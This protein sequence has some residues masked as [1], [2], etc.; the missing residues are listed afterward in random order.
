MIDL[1][2]SAGVME[3]VDLTGCWM[4]TS[5]ARGVKRGTPPKK[6]LNSFAIFNSEAG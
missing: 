3:P 2:A 4:P 1:A 6:A 5:Q